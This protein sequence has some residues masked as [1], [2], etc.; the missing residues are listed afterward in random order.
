MHNSDFL[1]RHQNS[2][3]SRTID[4]R[5]F[6]T[7]LWRRQISPCLVQLRF[8]T[9]HQKL[10]WARTIDWRVL[11]TRLWRRQ[12]SPYHVQLRF[13]TTLNLTVSYTIGLFRQSTSRSESHRVPYNSCFLWKHTFFL[14]CASQNNHELKPSI[15]QVF[16]SRLRRRQISP[17][18]ILFCFFDEKMQLQISPCLVW[19]FDLICLWNH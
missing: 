9:R 8:L 4:W 1:T 5:G 19:F 13:L 6:L 15:W 11:L 16:L 7:R 18:H 10:S 3:W 2:S 14:R 12:I 17:C